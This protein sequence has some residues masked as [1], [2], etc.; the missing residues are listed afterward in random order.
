MANDVKDATKFIAEQ[1]P[2]NMLAW[3]LKVD[4]GTV[5]RHKD[6]GN[7]L[8]V[9]VPDFTGAKC[10]NVAGTEKFYPIHTL[11]KDYEIVD[12][13]MAEV[14]YKDERPTKKST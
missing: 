13:P 10:K 7:A 1:D 3:Y 12:S 4:K 6:T 9:I 8:V 2:V 5:F 14:L 11:V